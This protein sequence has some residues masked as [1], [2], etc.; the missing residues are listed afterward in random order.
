MAFDFSH[1]KILLTGATRG[2]GRA[3]TYQLLDL[4]A[5]VLA[6][7]RDEAALEALARPDRH[8]CCRFGQSRDAPR[9]R[10]LGGRCP[11]RL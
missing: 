8:P 7:A 9:R 6:V 11:P 5:T 1:C 3:L 2:I 4:G 10:Q